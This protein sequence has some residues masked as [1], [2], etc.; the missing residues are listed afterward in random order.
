MASVRHIRSSVAD[1]NLT[2]ISQN[3]LTF[4]AKPK[5]LFHVPPIYYLVDISKFYNF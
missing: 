4:K 2:A 3:I 1:G 5:D